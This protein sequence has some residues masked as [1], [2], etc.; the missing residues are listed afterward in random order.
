MS[1]IITRMVKSWSSPIACLPQLAFKV[2]A[3]RVTRDRY[4]GSSNELT[5]SRTRFAY[6]TRA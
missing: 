3:R 1:E 5:N 6:E 4:P 2:V